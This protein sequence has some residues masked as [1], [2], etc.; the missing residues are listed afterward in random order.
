MSYCILLKQLYATLGSQQSKF[1][2]YFHNFK[3][4]YIQESALLRS[5][6]PR[7]TVSIKYF[8]YFIQPEYFKASLEEEELR[9]N[10]TEG[11][12]IMA[13]NG[14]VMGDDPLKNFAESGINVTSTLLK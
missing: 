8:S 9:I 2:Q 5:F 1:Q 14:W 7:F 11:C 10:T 6:D 4:N 13:C 3:S 12:L